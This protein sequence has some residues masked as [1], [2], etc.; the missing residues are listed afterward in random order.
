MLD[1]TRW[2]ILE[3][4]ARGSKTMSEIAERVGSSVANVSQHLKLL[5]AY[6]YVSKE[7]D[8]EGKPGRP[9]NVYA[10]SKDFSLIA[11]AEQPTAERKVLDLKD[12]YHKLILRILL[13]ED[14]EDHYYLHKLLWQNE[15]LIQKCQAIN[16]LRSSKDKIE[17]FVVTEHLEEI[18]ENFSNVVLENPQGEEKEVVCWSHSVD[19]IEE[20]LEK[21]DEHYEELVSDF[22]IIHDPEKLMQGWLR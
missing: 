20:G 22:H 12:R 4:V 2:S 5:E 7:K 14:E 10:L 6:D 15:E 19:E 3:E 18:R 1:D 17:L 9:Q 11:F 16:F 13:L 21:G 8:A